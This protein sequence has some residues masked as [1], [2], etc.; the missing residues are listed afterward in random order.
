MTQTMHQA[1]VKLKTA[2]HEAYEAGGLDELLGSI[3]DPDAINVFCDAVTDTL[4]RVVPT[5]TRPI[6]S[7]EQSCSDTTKIE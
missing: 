1:L 6:G 5:N 2:L 3:A 4:A 7:G